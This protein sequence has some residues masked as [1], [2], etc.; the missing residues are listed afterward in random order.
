MCITKKDI[1]NNTDTDSGDVP[2]P[3]DETVEGETE[4]IAQVEL[5]VEEVCC[6]EFC[7]H[8]NSLLNCLF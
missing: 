8:R 7:I 2:H 3:W 1:S 5:E 4:C 6:Q